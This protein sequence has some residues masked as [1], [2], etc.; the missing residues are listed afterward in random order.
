MEREP[1]RSSHGA[2]VRRAQRFLFSVLFLEPLQHFVRIV[3]RRY[4]RWTDEERQ[5]TEAR[6]IG[7]P[8]SGK[9]GRG[10]FYTP[11]SCPQT[12]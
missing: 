8:I 12:Y 9:A 5:L 4:P 10:E 1:T 7:E 3:S 11:P 2:L 6:G